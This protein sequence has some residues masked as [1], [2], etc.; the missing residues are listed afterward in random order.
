MSDKNNVILGK[1]ASV[2]GVK[3]WIKVISYTDPIENILKKL[4][5]SIMN[6]QTVLKQKIF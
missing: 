3:G 5:E 4:L 2:Y 1:F 6:T